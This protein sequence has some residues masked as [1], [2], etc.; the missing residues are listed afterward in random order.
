M[1]SSR[2]S[3]PS[4]AAAPAF[5]ARPNEPA[6]AWLQH[7]TASRS[8][9]GANRYN[10]SR[11]AT[12][13][14]A[15]S[16]DQHSFAI[17]TNPDRY[18]QHG[19]HFTADN[20]IACHACEAACSEKTNCRRTSASGQWVTWKVQLSG[21]PARQYLH[22]MQPLRRSVCLKGCRRA[23]TPS[24]PNMARCCRT[25]TSALAAAI[26]PGCARTTRRNSTRSRAKSRSATCASIA[27]KWD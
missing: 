16:E 25:P 7:R 19:F 11:T 9:S 24:S 15:E 10:W 5:K 23:P 26:A 1:P 22:G 4:P 21:F 18:K 3:E 27:S 2:A 6:Y 13:S 20:C 17:S 14:P 8:T 12:S